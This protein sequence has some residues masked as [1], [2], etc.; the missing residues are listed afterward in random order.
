MS[1]PVRKSPWKMNKAEIV[2]A[3]E[4]MQIP[5]HP[6]WTLPELRQTLIEHTRDAASIEER[7]ALRGIKPSRGLLLRMLRDHLQ[8]AG[9]HLSR[10][11]TW[12]YREV[13]QDYRDWAVQEVAAN[14]NHSVDL[15]KFAEWCLMEKNAKRTSASS[16]TPADDPEV[17][18]VVPPPPPMGY[19]DFAKRMTLGQ[20]EPHP[21]GAT[22]K[23]PAV[24][25]E[26]PAE[27]SA[28]MAVTVPQ[29]VQ[30]EIERMEA[31]VQALRQRHNMPPRTEMKG[32]TEG[33]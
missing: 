24:K 32:C 11:N 14:P 6:K 9:D 5:M 30:E 13:P 18:A 12:M 26:M 3:L 33:K 25:R 21:K 10:Y 15:H 8:P 23:K 29:E 16:A 7:Q 20:S 28:P 27:A 1:Q 31:Q 19:Q 22:P 4:S 2:L 17:K